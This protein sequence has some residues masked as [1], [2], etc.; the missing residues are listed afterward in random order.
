MRKSIF[1]E[2]KSTISQGHHHDYNEFGSL[3]IR[4]GK[5]R[6][7]ILTGSLN[8]SVNGESKTNIAYNRYSLKIAGKGIDDAIVKEESKDILSKMKMSM[9]K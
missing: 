5:K 6:D 2:R 9:K 3:E 7:S 4:M 8:L 1:R